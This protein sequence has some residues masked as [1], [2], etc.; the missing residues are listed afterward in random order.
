MLNIAEDDISV[1]IYTAHKKS[2]ERTISN[3]DS[4]FTI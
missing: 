2:V 3:L 1:C 4:E